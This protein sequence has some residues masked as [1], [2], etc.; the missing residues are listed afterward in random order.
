VAALSSFTDYQARR[1]GTRYRGADGRAALAHTVG[2][3][4]VA[5]PRL[6]AALVEAG[7]EADGSVR[8]PA[9][10]APYAGPDRLGGP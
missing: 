5:L 9:A 7:Q 1:A 8:L 4:A 10:L 3:A 6:I 2:G